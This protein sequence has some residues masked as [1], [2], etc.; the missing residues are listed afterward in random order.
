MFNRKVVVIR[1]QILSLLL[2]KQRYTPLMSRLFVVIRSQIF[3]FAS[4]K[5]TPILGILIG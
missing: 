2:R 4:A 5:T 3:I 1:S